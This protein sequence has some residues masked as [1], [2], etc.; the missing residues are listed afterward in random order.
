M[1]VTL[2]EIEGN[3]RQSVESKC[4]LSNLAVILSGKQQLS[5]WENFKKRDPARN[6][7]QGITQ[8]I[9]W[10]EGEKLE[11][12]LPR[13]KCVSTVYAEHI[14]FWVCTETVFSGI[15]G[16]RIK[17]DQHNRTNDRKKGN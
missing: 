13:K 3:P 2:E 9:Q 11:S 10:N 16:L 8:P 4:D 14:F 5:C 6:H 7:S 1:C 12:I 15:T 17:H